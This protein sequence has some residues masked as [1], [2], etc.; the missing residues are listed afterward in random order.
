MRTWMTRVVAVLLALC[1][2]WV[3]AASGGMILC[4]QA[5]GHVAFGPGGG[6]V[7][8]GAERLVE[9][10]ES[11]TAAPCTEC[12]DEDGCA[13]IPGKGLLHR[14]PPGVAQPRATLGQ[15]VPYALA[16]TPRDA[17]TPPALPLPPTHVLAG[18]HDMR[19]RLAALRTVVLRL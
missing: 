17:G 11:T 1:F 9:A 18:R 6:L 7:C 10:V 19:L 13:H 3:S 16:M 15:A 8:A 2:P 12:L 5:S 14:P 4:F